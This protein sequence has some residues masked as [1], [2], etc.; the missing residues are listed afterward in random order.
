[1]NTVNEDDSNYCDNWRR[2]AVVTPKI[3]QGRI[4]TSQRFCFNHISGSMFTTLFSLLVFQLGH[5]CATPAPLSV[6]V[7][8]RVTSDD[9][10]LRFG[11]WYIVNRFLVLVFFRDDAESVEFD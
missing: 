10:S 3:Y 2:V 4:C 8:L 1:M 6:R 9:P 5:F 7:R 11:V